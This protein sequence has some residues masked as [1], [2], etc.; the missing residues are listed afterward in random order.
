MDYEKRNEACISF[1]DENARMGRDRK[2]VRRSGMRAG[3]L[4]RR[5]RHGLLRMA[6]RDKRIHGGGI[7]GTGVPRLAAL[8]RRAGDKKDGIDGAAGRER[9]GM[10]HVFLRIRDSRLTPWVS[11]SSACLLSL[12][13]LF[14][15]RLSIAG[16]GTL[17][18][19]FLSS[20]LACMAGMMKEVRES[21]S[22]E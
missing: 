5:P 2:S 16:A 6:G 21:G 3:N 17:G 13:D 15:A 19:V 8:A 12:A 14:G 1:T 10:R 9:G 18:V 20:F 11:V 22:G 4:R 7:C